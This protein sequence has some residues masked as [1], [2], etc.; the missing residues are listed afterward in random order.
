MLYYRHKQTAYYLVTMFLKW[1]SLCWY[2]SSLHFLGNIGVLDTASKFKWEILK[3][4]RKKKSSLRIVTFSILW[5]VS[6]GSS[7]RAVQVVWWRS[8]LQ[9]CS[10]HFNISDDRCLM[11]LANVVLEPSHSWP[12]GTCRGAAQ[13]NTHCWVSTLPGLGFFTCRHGGYTG[14]VSPWEHD[15]VHLGGKVCTYTHST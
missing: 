2:W 3:W 1:Q 15:P 8:E 11:F 10:R 13:D 12:L 7:T 6:P 9:I 5:D 14:K 4:R